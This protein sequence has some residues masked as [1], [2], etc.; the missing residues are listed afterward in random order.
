VGG[1]GVV[2][3]VLT[4]GTVAAFAV[5]AEIEP[6]GFVFGGGGVKVF[7]LLADVA[8][9]TVLVPDLD[10]GFAG[11]VGV[12]D[13]EIVEPLFALNVPARGKYDDASAGKCGQ[14]MLDAAVAERVID[15]VLLGLAGEIGL[16]NVEGVIPAGE[17]VQ[18]ASELYRSVGEVALDADGSGGLHHF[19]MAGAGPL[20]MSGGV[21]GGASGG[22]YVGD[23]GCAYRPGKREGQDQGS[24]HANLPVYNGI[25]DLKMR[26]SFGWLA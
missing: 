16:C 4:A 22:A 3:Y 9:E 8:G 11:F 24:E 14:V 5:G 23:G 25:L 21:T 7:L 19:A 13:V 1:G 15:S 6:G 17:A 10:H 2:G 18:G 26:S 20:G 12:A